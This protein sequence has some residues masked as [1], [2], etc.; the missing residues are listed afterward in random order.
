M[1]YYKCKKCGAEFHNMTL[2]KYA[3]SVKC[4]ECN[5]LTEYSS[6]DEELWY[7]EKDENGE[8]IRPR[9]KG[10]DEMDARQKAADYF[11]C[12]PRDVPYFVVQRKG[13]FKP[14]IICASKPKAV[15][16]KRDEGAKRILMWEYENRPQ[17]WADINL[18]KKTIVYP[19][20]LGDEKQG[21]EKIIGLKKSK[22]V[23]EC[24]HFKLI[25]EPQG[26]V[27]FPF[28]P[29]YFNDIDKLIQIGNEYGEPINHGMFVERLSCRVPFE[30]E[31]GVFLKISFEDF[32]LDGRMRYW[33]KDNKICLLNT[34]SFQG[35]D[36]L[37]D[38]IKYYRLIGQKYV[39]TEISG[40]GGGGSSIK[41]AVIGGLIA[42]DV[43]A[44]VAS[45][46]E[47]DEVKGVSTVHDEQVVLVYSTDLK[48]VIAFNSN[49]YGVFTKLIPEKDYDVVVLSSKEES[50]ANHTKNVADAVR[51]YKKLLDEGIINI[52]E[53]EK[54]KNE[55]LDL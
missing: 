49:A 4:L 33:K 51:E 6:S 16:H 11:K 2:A 12:D 41:G 28:Y 50:I 55:L 23:G 44:I 1:A 31:Q 9:F 40:G 5:A 20:I 17:I 43:G 15:I 48:Q 32:N 24:K 27:E 8:L 38:K 22:D 21:F 36:I 25:L 10:A 54:K 52:E 47:V 29:G 45:R 53:F 37:V 39:T 7:N 14:F 42:G 19:Y 26:E 34:D 13:V 18:E 30:A 3:T 46:K 35:I